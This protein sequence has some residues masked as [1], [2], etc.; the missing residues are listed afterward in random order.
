LDF[1][2]PPENSTDWVASLLYKNKAIE[3]MEAKDQE[4][5]ETFHG[6]F[7]IDWLIEEYLAERKENDERAEQAKQTVWKEYHDPET[8]ARWKMERE[9]G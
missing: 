1:P 8:G 3:V 7:S 4:S 6:V 9:V 5:E 2:T